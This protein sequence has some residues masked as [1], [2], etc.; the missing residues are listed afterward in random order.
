MD[1]YCPVEHL[2]DGGRFALKTYSGQWVCLEAGSLR[3]TGQF[4]DSTCTFE[5]AARS[6]NFLVGPTVSERKDAPLS[7][8]VYIR[9]TDDLATISDEER[10]ALFRTSPSGH[11]T[12]GLLPVSAG[13]GQIVGTVANA[14]LREWTDQRRITMGAWLEDE[15]TAFQVFMQCPSHDM[16][17]WPV[18]ME[19]F[20][21]VSTLGGIHVDSVGVL[22]VTP[23]QETEPTPEKFSFDAD[24]NLKIGDQWV[25]MNGVRMVGSDLPLC[26]QAFDAPPRAAEDK[27]TVRATCC[28]YVFTLGD[29]RL[30]H[31]DGKQF[32]AASDPTEY[33]FLDLELTD[34][35]PYTEA[36]LD[37]GRRAAT[38]SACDLEEA[39]LAYSIVVGALLMIG[40]PAARGRAAETGCMGLLRSDSRVS[41]ALDEVLNVLRD[42]SALQIG[43]ATSVAILAS[44]VNLIG[45]IIEQNLLWKLLWILVKGLGVPFL[46]GKAVIYV[47]KLA[48]FGVAVAQWGANFVIY[49]YGVIRSYLNYQA[50][51]ADGGAVAAG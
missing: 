33:S 3:T 44:I 12:I 6:E 4:D 9:T 26:L 23:H 5:A 32:V 31:Y 7:T 1:I 19:F 43:L 25:A 46:I 50:C 17:G 14:F 8:F 51:L 45:A 20:V 16:G 11:G 28:G 40:L 49:A 13:P 29:G 37:I 41:A 38:A 35:I 21:N 30:V 48:S 10:A 15:K 42:N 18:G 24:G 36:Q 22:R 34:D 39:S 27:V 47:M 2:Q